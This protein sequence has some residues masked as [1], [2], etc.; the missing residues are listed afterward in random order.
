MYWLEVSVVTDGEGAEAV[1]EALRPFAHDEIVVL[2][3]LGDAANP[4][5]DALEPVVTVKIY[6]PEEKDTPTI[7]RRI[8][9]NIYY[10]G[11]IYPLPSPNFKEMEDVD[12]AHAWK[13]HYHPFRLGKRLWIQ[14]SW[15][16]NNDLDSQTQSHP[17][18]DIRIIMDPGMAFGT[19]SHPTTQMCLMALEQIVQPGTRMLDVGTGSGILG[20]A[21]AKLGCGEI[22]GIDIDE[23]AIKASTLNIAQNNVQEQITIRQ[24]TFESVKEKPWDIVVINILAQVIVNL[25]GEGLMEYVAEDGVLILSGIIKEKMDTVETAVSEAGGYI[26]QTL[27]MGDWVTIM[28]RPI[29]SH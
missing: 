12:W 1:A 8:E 9:E 24:G 11:M 3:Q 21:A 2:E 25:L 29:P 5:P 15:V 27:T 22:L 6:I 14:P 19:G 18:D 23:Q 20:I 28:A 26:S 17:S 7:R 13:D 16:K 4:E 10:M